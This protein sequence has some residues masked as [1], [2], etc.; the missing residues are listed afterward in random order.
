MGLTIH[1]QFVNSSLRY[2]N[3]LNGFCISTY[4]NA[5]RWEMDE[6]YAVQIKTNNAFWCRSSKQA[7]YCGKKENKNGS[8]VGHT[9]NVICPLLAQWYQAG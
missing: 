2:G 9:Y 7:F 4:I 5:C 1:S 8:S 3:D 6:S